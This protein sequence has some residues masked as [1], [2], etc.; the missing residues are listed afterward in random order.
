M[1]Q[2]QAKISFNRMQLTIIHSH[3][4]HLMQQ[5][6]LKSVYDKECI[7]KHRTLGPMEKEKEKRKKIILQFN[8]HLLHNCF[9][10]YIKIPS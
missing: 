4:L 7:I 8:L 9:S 6:I 2:S 5:V 10:Y 3:V 1:N